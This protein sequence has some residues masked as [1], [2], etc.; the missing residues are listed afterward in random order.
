MSLFADILCTYLQAVIG[1]ILANQLLSKSCWVYSQLILIYH[2]NGL[3]ELEIKDSYKEAETQRSKKLAVHGE[4]NS[5]FL[6]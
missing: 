4:L 1:W 3:P 2:F 5:N 6:A